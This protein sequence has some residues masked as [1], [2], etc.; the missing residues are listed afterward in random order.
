MSYTQSS[1]KDRTLSGVIAIGTGISS[2]GERVLIPALQSMIDVAK[3]QLAELSKIE[4]ALLEAVRHGLDLE[5]I[6]KAIYEVCHKLPHVVKKELEKHLHGEH[7][8]TFYKR[9]VKEALSAQIEAM[10]KALRSIFAE[11]GAYGDTVIAQANGTLETVRGIFSSFSIGTLL[12]FT[13][14]VWRLSKGFISDATWDDF[15]N[16]LLI[17]TTVDASAVAGGFL[18]AKVTGAGGALLTK[19]LVV[20][21]YGLLV[22]TLPIA[23]AVG[24][25]MVGGYY[26]A[27]GTRYTINYL[28]GR[29]RETPA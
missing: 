28:F 25:G 11:L 21:K 2:T 17:E 18:F 22:K 26:C 24:G 27:K 19:G 9:M 15:L 1:E 13:R 5:A 23:C 8:G 6:S 7:I 12:F 29:E 10:E 20:A 14:F 3:G 16:T 4:E